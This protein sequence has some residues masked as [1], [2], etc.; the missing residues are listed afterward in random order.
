MGGPIEIIWS[1][2]RKEWWEKER[3]TERKEEEK[4]AID[5]LPLS[6]SLSVSTYLSCANDSAIVKLAYAVGFDRDPDC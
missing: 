4:R 6:L 3:E 5:D 2:V 1:K